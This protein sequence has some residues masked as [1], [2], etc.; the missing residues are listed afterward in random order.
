MRLAVL[1]HGNDLQPQENIQLNF[2]RA[3]HA[4][5]CVVFLKA[6]VSLPVCYTLAIYRF[7]SPWLMQL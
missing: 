4:A 3:K 1:F 2:C 5:F 7:S 6:Y